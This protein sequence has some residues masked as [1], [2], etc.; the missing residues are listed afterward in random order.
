MKVTRDELEAMCA[1]LIERMFPVLQ[2]ALKV[3][4]NYS[5]N[6]PNELRDIIIFGG[7]TRV[8]A[9]QASILKGTKRLVLIIVTEVI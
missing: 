6:I 3:A 1:D 5:S 4:E 8:P 2:S 9:V 7:G